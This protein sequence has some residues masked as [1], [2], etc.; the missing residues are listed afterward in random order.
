M[1]YYYTKTTIFSLTLFVTTFFSFNLFA[2]NTIIDIPELDSLEIS[3][4]VNYFDINDGL[5]EGN[6]ASILK[7]RIA[8][9]KFFVLGENHSSTQVSK[10]T[11][12]LVPLLDESGYKVA[13]FEVGPLSA[14]KLKELSKI[15]DSTEARLK[16]FNNKYFTPSAGMSAIPMF[17]AAVDA[18]FLKAFAEK[19]MEIWGIDQEFIFSVLFLGDD[20]VE[21]KS[22]YAN[23]EG[24]KDAWARA[25]AIAEA[26]FEKRPFNALTKL[27]KNPDFQQFEKMFESDDLYAQEVFKRLHESEHI[28]KSHHKYRVDY[29][30]SN[31]LENYMAFEEVNKEAR[32]FIKIGSIHASTTSR[33]LGY[34]DVGSLTEEIA[35]IE[36]AKSTNVI[37]PRATYDGKDYRDLCPSLLN[38]HKKDSWIIIDLEKLRNDLNSNKFQIITHPDN[39]ELNRIING[40]DLLLIPPVDEKPIDNR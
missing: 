3:E 11:E 27:I 28:Y 34:F 38:F 39:R 25:K 2:Q 14:E 36:N 37:I 24:I 7:E 15:P 31:F 29:I 22:H 23:Y 40:F 16:A 20:L 5:P 26:E 21:S 12:S 32:Y 6:G 30:V 33:S 8:S 35:R 4:A 9:S 1:K 17:F 18:A 19:K 10:L 13:A